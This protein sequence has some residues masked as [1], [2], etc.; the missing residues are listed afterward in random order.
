MVWLRYVGKAVVRILPRRTG[1][2]RTVIKVLLADDHSLVRT[3]IK[4]ILERSP[5]IRVVAEASDGQEALEQYKAVHPDVVI[6]DIS[7]P[8]MD[9]LETTKSILAVDPQAQILMLTMYPERQYA[10]RALKAGALGYITKGTSTAEL[11]NAVRSVAAR[12]RFL[13]EEGIDAVTTRL[14]AGG[15]SASLIE[16]LSDRELQVLCMIARGRRIIE[17]ADELSVGAK[18]VETYRGRLLRKLGLRNNADI[19]RFA[20]DNA[21]V[22]D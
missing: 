13:S 8:N 10:V 19:C 14:L 2:G 12:K 21:L 4:G 17:I 9:G 15:P 6:L 5:D 16:N 7:M 18:T 11:H 3:G 1:M 22:E 20:Y